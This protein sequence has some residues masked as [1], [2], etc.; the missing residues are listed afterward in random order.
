MKTLPLA[1]AEFLLVRRIHATSALTFVALIIVAALVEAAEIKPADPSKP[2][3]RI[4]APMS[5]KSGAAGPVAEM[6]S[7]HP[8]LVIWSV[9]DLRLASDS[10]GVLIRLTPKDAKAFAVLTRKYNQ[11]LLFL[12]GQG[13]IFEAMQI[14]ALLEDGILGFKYSDQPALAEYLRRRFR[15]AEFK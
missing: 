14:T 3:F 1:V 8:L 2:L 7:S 13:R 11:R 6:D 9:A 15:I 12:E 5:V 10:K 4:F